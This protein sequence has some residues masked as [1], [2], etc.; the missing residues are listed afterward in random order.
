MLEYEKEKKTKQCKTI[1]CNAIQLNEIQH[2]LPQKQS[3]LQS[4]VSVLSEG[5]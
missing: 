4:Q 1:Q 5:V 2:N 3:H